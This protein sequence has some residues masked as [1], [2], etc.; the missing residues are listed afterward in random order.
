M[1]IVFSTK[2]VGRTSF[3][4]TCRI[5]YDYG[6]ECFEIHDALKERSQHHD[7]ILRRDRTADAK[8]KLINRSLSVSALS[9]PH[10]LDSNE[11]SS[12]E[13]VK[14]VDMASMAGISNI[15]VRIENEVSFDVLKNK[16]QD[17]ISR[18]ENSDV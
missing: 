18:A 15:L 16:L 5:A 6:F 9:Y 1:K 14:Y 12:D 8:R 17:A 11:A 13:L 7:S 2:N 10:P 4:D 3:L